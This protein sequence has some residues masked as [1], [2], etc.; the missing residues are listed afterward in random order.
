MLDPYATLEVG[1][2]ASIDEIKRSFRRLAKELHPDLNPN[3][4]AYARRF[5]DIAAAY[6]MLSDEGKR[7]DYDRQAEAARIVADRAAAFRPSRHSDSAG[8]HGFEEGLDSFF[9]GRTARGAQAR[10]AQARGAQARGAQARGERPTESVWRGSD[11]LQS[12]RVSFGEAALGTRKR[13][14]LG[15]E[16]VLDVVV[17]PA[18][19]E[20]QTLRLKGQGTTGML[21][22]SPGDMLIEIAVEPHATF[23]RRDHDIHMV[24]SVTVQEAVQGGTVTV[25]TIHGAV[26]LR[27]PRGSN[28]DTVLR[29]RGKGVPMPGDNAAGDQY[30]TLKVV[31]P[32]DDPDFARLVEQWAKRRAP[33]RAG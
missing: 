27:V 8:H 9:R 1:H 32:E 18:T 29:L 26:Q 12:L 16:R 5:R 14:R 19:V 17:P 15:D 25:P 13:I 21:G 30:V 3:N 11:I 2:D 24:A 4:A 22:T 33:S 20:G 28:T 23:T 7:R 6:D 31:L 10:D